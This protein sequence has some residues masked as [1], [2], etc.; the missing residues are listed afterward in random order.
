MFVILKKKDSELF[1]F[2]GYFQGYPDYNRI[3]GI[4]FVFDCRI[5]PLMEDCVEAY[6]RIKYECP[7]IRIV[8]LNELQQRIQEH[9]LEK[10]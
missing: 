8:P 3:R 7:D 1:I 4:D 6:N 5:F 9:F 10:I 2:I